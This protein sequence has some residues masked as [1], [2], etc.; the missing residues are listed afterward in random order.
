MSPCDRC[1]SRRAFI[2]HAAAGGLA[3][4]SV[5]CGDGFISGTATPVPRLPPNKPPSGQVVVVVAD[6]PELAN[7]GVLV[8]VASFYAAKRTGAESF[9]AFSMACT[10]E[11]CLTD[12]VGGQT[13]ECPCHGSRFDSDGSV[14][15]GPA[16]RSLQTL[17]TS[18]N[19][20]TGTL[21]IN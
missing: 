4:A 11:G 8:K 5:A 21:T 18:Y 12:L 20:A 10:H 6:V 16:M 15:V 19:S 2:A 9:E 17:P 1:V 13:F 3:A 7:V 14:I